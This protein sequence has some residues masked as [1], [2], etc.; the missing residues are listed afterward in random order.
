MPNTPR[1]AA[2][3]AYPGYPGTHPRTTPTSPTSSAPIGVLIIVFIVLLPPDQILWSSEHKFGV[4]HTLF[5]NRVSKSCLFYHKVWKLIWT[6]SPEMNKDPRGVFEF[7]WEKS[8]QPC[9]RSTESESDG[10][11]TIGTILNK[12]GRFEHLKPTETHRRWEAVRIIW[13]DLLLSNY[14]LQGIKW[15]Y[16][17][18]DW[19]QNISSSPGG[20]KVD[21]SWD[22]YFFSS[23]RQGS[24]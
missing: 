20:N 8:E 1:N 3:A 15:L 2:R 4:L 14:Q 17:V 11:A 5:T 13:E 18:L 21:W 9:I 7:H 24:L 12:R 16:K 23:F 6:K 10:I 22:N 19:L